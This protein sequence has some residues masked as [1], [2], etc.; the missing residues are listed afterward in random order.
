MHHL[1]GHPNVV[2]LVNVF[3]DKR[4]VHIVMELCSGGELFDRIVKRGHYSEKNAA[5]I[6][7]TIVEVVQ[8]CHSMGVVHRDL[9]P[10][11]F[12]LSD[13]GASAE[14]KATDFGLSSFFK[15]G[16]K[17]TDI[18]GSAY[19]VAPEVRRRHAPAQCRGACARPAQVVY[20]Q[21]W[22]ALQALGHSASATRLFM[23]RACPSTMPL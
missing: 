22:A 14:L 8:H 7:R 20:F 10:E 16:V 3:E 6:I 9:K 2:K 4:N 23:S 21:A 17:F 19:Y 15:D 12:L 11:N 5:Q 18:V 1:S 13:D